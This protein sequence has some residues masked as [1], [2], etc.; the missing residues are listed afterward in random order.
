MKKINLS[1]VGL[2][3]LMNS[4]LV[5]AGAHVEHGGKNPNNAGACKEARIGKVKPAALSEVAPGADF[6]FMLFDANNPNQ[7]EVTV[8]KIVVP[9]TIESKGD[10]A[11]VHGK[12]PESLKATPVRINV[13]VKGKSSKCNVE[14]GWLL[15]ITG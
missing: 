6:S 12:L 14:E 15:K 5:L 11:V 1:V 9:V 3:A 13:K 10:M 7:I 2:L 4:S 8:K